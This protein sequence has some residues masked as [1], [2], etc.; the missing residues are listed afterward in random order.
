MNLVGWIVVGGLAGWVVALACDDDDAALLVNIVVGSL[1]AL[2]GAM[3]APLLGRDVRPAAA[4]LDLVAILVALCGALVLLALVRW[5]GWR[6][7][8]PRRRVKEGQAD[9]RAVDADGAGARDTGST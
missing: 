8:V 9:A 3:C 4:G 5:F 1:G 2:I 6:V 7:P